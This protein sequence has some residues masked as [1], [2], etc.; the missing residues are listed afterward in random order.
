MGRS[1]KQAQ[2]FLKKQKKKQEKAKADLREQQ[3]A[4]RSPAKHAKESG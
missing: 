3:R 2:G 4:E 1:S